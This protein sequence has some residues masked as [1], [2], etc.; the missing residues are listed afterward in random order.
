M[1]RLAW[2]FLL[3]STLPSATTSS[4]YE[5]L[6]VLKHASKNDIKKA[7][8]QKARL[9]H[10]D[11]NPDDRQQAQALFEKVSEAY[12]ILGNDKSRKIYDQDIAYSAHARR[13]ENR[14]APQSR[15]QKTFVFKQNGRTFLF[16]EDEIRGFGS[17]EQPQQSSLLPAFLKHVMLF[18]G[19]WLLLRGAMGEHPSGESH[20][21]ETKDTATMFRSIDV[22]SVH[23]PHVFPFQ[24][25]VLRRRAERCVIFFPRH[26]QNPLEWQVFESIALR[27]VT[28]RL[29]FLYIDPTCAPKWVEFL[30]NEFPDEHRPPLVCVFGSS[31]S[32]VKC[33]EPIGADENEISPL[34]SIKDRV[35]R[36]L[37]GIIDGT[38]H[39]QLLINDLPPDCR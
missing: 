3:A 18:F 28:D 1:L 14:Y 35:V 29:S 11:K 20:R 33:F 37:E 21:R 7:Y 2:I 15:A 5:T 13:H 32:K 24:P 8:Y 27:F 17:P 22:A 34:G 19:I 30:K 38:S 25:R 36:W 6:G 31:G 23:A 10:P 12:E 16:T 9:S 39:L 26:P 4:H